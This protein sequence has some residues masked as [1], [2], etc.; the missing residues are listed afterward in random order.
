LRVLIAYA[1][2]HGTTEGC[3]RR[4]E[5]LLP[6][7]C[8]LVDV[9]R[10]KNCDP[11]AYDLVVVGGSIHAGQVQKAVTMFCAEHSQVLLSRKLG[12]FLC[13]MEKGETAQKEF[14]TA[15][16]EELRRHT[17][18]SAILGGEFRLERM[19]WLE[20]AIVRKVAKVDH[21]VSQVDE[22]ALTAFARKLS[23][24]VSVAATRA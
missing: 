19:N 13:C 15:Y 2:R 5:E 11:A 14:D 10:V 1:S 23:E 7:D 22:D 8:T 20:R 17:A 3:A 12:L 24:S 4:L 9:K 21:N 6:G 16:P 18:A